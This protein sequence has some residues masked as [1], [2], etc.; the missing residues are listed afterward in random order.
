MDGRV[1]SLSL[2]GSQYSERPGQGVCAGLGQLRVQC[3]GSLSGLAS[4]HPS[5]HVPSSTTS[6]TIPLSVSLPW[7]IS[8]R[9]RNLGC[10]LLVKLHVA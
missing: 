5:P 7:N 3:A 9:G 6:H 4:S 8:P 2:L 10:C 1:G